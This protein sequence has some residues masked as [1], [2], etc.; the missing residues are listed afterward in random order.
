MEYVKDTHLNQNPRTGKVLSRKFQE[1]MSHFPFQLYQLFKCTEFKH[2]CI[3]NTFWLL[4]LI[5]DLADIKTQNSK[6][7]KWK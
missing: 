4:I 1:N 5:S 3:A 6:C 7:R 2:A